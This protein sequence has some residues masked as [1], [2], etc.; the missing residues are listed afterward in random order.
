M[1]LVCCLQADVKFLHDTV[2]P[3][4][5]APRLSGHDYSC[6]REAIYIESSPISQV[7][8]TKIFDDFLTW[9]RSRPKVTLVDMS[10]LVS[11]HELAFSCA[12]MSKR[13]ILLSRPFCIIRHP[14]KKVVSGSGRI[15]EEVLY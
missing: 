1:H 4:L 3:R 10:T 12:P 6:I 14:F 9:L 8:A 5:T 2:L 11:L 13:V 15:V 7:S